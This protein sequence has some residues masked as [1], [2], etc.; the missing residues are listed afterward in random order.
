MII[1]IEYSMVRKIILLF[2]LIH[3][4]AFAMLYLALIIGCSPDRQSNG[5]T[6]EKISLGP[7]DFVQLD[8]ITIHDQK[9][10][11]LNNDDSDKEVFELELENSTENH[12]PLMPPYSVDEISSQSITGVEL[13]DV[14]T[15]ENSKRIKTIPII[16]SLTRELL[17]GGVKAIT[18]FQESL[19]VFGMEFDMDSYPDAYNRYLSDPT[20]SIYSHL[21]DEQS[22]PGFFYAI[23]AFIS[24]YDLSGVEG[25]K[26][27]FDG[28]AWDIISDVF[29][30]DNGVGFLILS[31]W[32]SFPFN[33]HASLGALDSSGFS[34]K[35]KLSDEHGLLR[36]AEN[37]ILDFGPRHNDNWGRSGAEVYDT[38]FTLDTPAVTAIDSSMLNRVFDAAY[39]RGDFIY[40][41]SQNRRSVIDLKS[42]NVEIFNISY[43]SFNSLP[44][45]YWQ[46]E[47]YGERSYLLGYI[48]IHG[49]KISN[50]M[51]MII[52]ADPINGVFW[53]FADKD[54]DRLYRYLPDSSIRINSM[55]IVE[56][57]V[58]FTGT[59]DRQM[60]LMFLDH[61]GDIQWQA[62]WGEGSLRGITEYQG[63]YFVVG[64]RIKMHSEEYTGDFDDWGTSIMYLAEID[65]SWL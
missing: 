34:Y 49:Y 13:F 63:R 11:I 60:L 43:D 12:V 5:S 21:S 7:E 8:K 4:K 42:G 29:P 56:E 50:P 44:V 48:G 51:G 62:Y 59:K 53:S 46:A 52:D 35:Y 17:D 61:D 38:T 31:R 18:T 27:K 64:D 23:N 6:D 33:Y 15:V 30:M 19:I 28:T 37:I 14:L 36:R 58:L 65:L 22:I 26:H 3:L 32:Y 39:R 54:N 1:T 47:S 41:W 55:F 9:P 16:W 2:K 10:P 24:Q 20:R 40:S 45:V 25:F 57:G